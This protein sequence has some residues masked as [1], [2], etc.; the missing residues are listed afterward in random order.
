MFVGYIIRQFTD[1]NDKKVPTETVGQ[2]KESDRQMVY[3]FNLVPGENPVQVQTN[4]KKFSWEHWQSSS[5]VAN[6]SAKDKS[7]KKV[8]LI[9]FKLSDNL[10]S[11]RWYNV[12]N[13]DL[14][15]PHSSEI[16]HLKNQMPSWSDVEI[17]EFGVPKVGFSQKLRVTICK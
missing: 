5:T 4:R 9:R 17:V 14:N 11:T 12:C 6:V 13:L 15:N 3:E 10:G 7:K 1:D 16:R 8:L 2:A